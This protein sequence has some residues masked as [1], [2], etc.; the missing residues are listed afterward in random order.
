MK[1]LDLY[2][3]RLGLQIVKPK[4]I[5]HSKNNCLLNGEF[6]QN[7]VCKING[8]RS[9]FGQGFWNASLARLPIA[10]CRLPVAGLRA[11]Q[12]KI[13][14]Q[15]SRRKRR[16]KSRVQKSRTKKTRSPNRA[17]FDKPNFAEHLKF[18]LDLPTRAEQSAACNS[19][20]CFDGIPKPPDCRPLKGIRTH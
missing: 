10:G 9:R 7:R 3:I 2:K 4:P 13:A 1:T 16:A 20:V 8:L 5:G 15:K 11:H 6:D 14:R 12:L 19:S 17:R 18:F